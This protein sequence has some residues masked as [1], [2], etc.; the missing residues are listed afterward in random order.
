VATEQDNA[1]TGLRAL[2]PVGDLLSRL[3]TEP[4]VTDVPALL[5][6]AWVREAIEEARA[7]IRAATPDSTGEAGR[8]AWMD[9]C[10]RFVLARAAERSLAGAR[11]VINATGVLLHTNLGR[12]PLPAAAVRALTEAM[13]GYSS[14]EMDLE[15]GR[16]RS[17]LEPVRRLLPLVTGAEAGIAVHNNAAA[18]HLALMAIA[19]GREVIVSRGHLVEIGGSFRLPEIMAASGARLREVG[20]TNRTRLSDYQAAIGPETAL[21]LQVHPSNFR[22]IGFA[23]EVSTRDLAALA[24]THG[25][26][27]MHDVG[28]GAL[29]AHG[30]LAFGEPTV[31]A[32][33]EDGAD[34]VCFS[35][36]KLLGGPQAGILVG[37]REWIDR[38][39]KHPVARVVRLDKT[40]LAALAGTLE[41][42]LD[43]AT[44]RT[45]IPLLTLL[46]RDEAEL[47]EMA[48]SLADQLRPV[49]P[50]PWEIDVA[51][52]P[53]EVG[54][55][56]LPG[57]TLPSRAV[58][59]R[60]PTHHASAVSRALRLAD[61]AVAGRIEDDR[62]LLD[63]RAL[64][65]G[66]AELIVRVMATLSEA[67][68]R[69]SPREP[70]R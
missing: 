58:R 48:T 42:W 8:E 15:S 66:D 30:A 20:S 57:V 45:R 52:V 31:Q 38:L 24:H 37:K 10:T 50:P 33:L 64:L 47:N 18:V 60:H 61:P 5:R 34:L 11:R 54:G 4:L 16:R 13:S 69:P 26:P 40:T 41:A 39:S 70:K 49:L 17:R 29:R 46:A 27:L 9:W 19:P 36:D 59:F 44:V 43:P 6:Q 7:V 63:V 12:A 32:S 2:P 23:E 55:G 62:V 1:R 67:L 22:L 28:S 68:S 21:L 56:T 53:C 35:G 25:L 3:E 14:L 65:P 51:S